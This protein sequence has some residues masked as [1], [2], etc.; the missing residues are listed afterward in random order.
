MIGASGSPPPPAGTPAIVTEPPVDP[1]AGIR[2]FVAARRLT[3]LEKVGSG[4]EFVVYRAIALGGA[5]VALRTPVGERFQ[6]N[7]ND[8][9]VDTRS[10]LAWEYAV[11]SH[12]SRSGFPV[13]DPHELVF[14][15]PDLLVSEFLPD[16][17]SGA[18]QVG[19]GAL[20]RR[21][22]RLPLPPIGTPV[23]SEGRSAA[24]L[25]PARIVRRWREIAALV[26]DLPP[27]PPLERLRAALAGR[28]AVSL[29]H[30]DV[31]ATNLRCVEG[32]VVG[33]LDWSNALIGDPELE[34]G[35]MAESAL[36]ADNAL[37]FDAVLAGYGAPVA[38][39]SAAFW[40]YRLDAAAMLALVFLSEAPDAVRGPAAVERLLAVRHR[41]VAKTF[42]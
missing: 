12:L 20:L 36:H 6:S 34:L 30:L 33:L 21:L 18:D 40:V 28:P 41:L 15:E 29:L 27:P 42:R 23:A 37:D 1:P 9:N 7:A 17:G 25:L 22:H 32:Q 13:A 26:P 24:E 38:V 39:D 19:L 5:Q 3:H 35:R 14:G 2:R 10:L 16:D 8:P 31:R 11:T 4:L